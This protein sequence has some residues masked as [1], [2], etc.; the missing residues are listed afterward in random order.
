MVGFSSAS[1]FS[2]RKREAVTQRDRPPD[3][4]EKSRELIKD[5]RTSES[6]V[7]YQIHSRK[8]RITFSIHIIVEYIYI[9]IYNFIIIIE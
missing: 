7:P 6:A 9:Y 1:L 2:A 5:G 8:T 4:E 3:A